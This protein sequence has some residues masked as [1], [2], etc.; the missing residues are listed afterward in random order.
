MPVVNSWLP[1]FMLLRENA[2]V[3][4]AISNEEIVPSPTSFFASPLPTSIANSGSSPI[5]DVV[6]SRSEEPKSELQSL[7]PNSYALLCLKKKQQK[8]THT[9]IT[10][11]TIKP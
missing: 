10:H 1:V 5:S 9:N 6:V 2:S 11:T 4:P 3:G 8:Y 7:M